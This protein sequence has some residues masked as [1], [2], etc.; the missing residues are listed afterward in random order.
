MLMDSRDPQPRPRSDPLLSAVWW[1]LTALLVLCIIVGIAGLL[2][3]PA[4][5]ANEAYFVR[6]FERMG[7]EPSALKWVGLLGSLVAAAMALTFFFLRDLRRII[8]SVAQGHPFDPM[9]ADRLRRMA[10]LSIAIQ[11]VLVPLTR[12]IFWFDALPYQPNVH[13]G[14]DGISIGGIVLTLI[15]FVLARVF[16]TGAAMHEDLEGTI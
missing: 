7:I 2:W 10:W 11:I 14:S 1:L 8:D 5:L 16:R 12:L 15:L 9:N 3:Y 13:H 6:A 4:L